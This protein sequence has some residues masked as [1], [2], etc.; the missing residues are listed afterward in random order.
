MTGLIVYNTGIPATNNNPSDDQPHMLINTDSGDQ[1]WDVD[2]VPFNVNYSGTHSQNTYVGFST[3]TF[4]SLVGPAS[5]IAYP[6]A[7]IDKATTAQYYFKNQDATYPLSAV[8]AFGVFQP[9]G[10][11]G[12]SQDITASNSF[13]VVPTSTAF[14][15]QIT[16]A[17]VTTWVVTLNANATTSDNAVVFVMA[18]GALAGGNVNAR[19]LAWSLTANV[20]T[21]RAS[22]LP[23]TPIYFAILQ[24]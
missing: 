16:T 5:S 1:I 10:S 9:L 19:P 7:G 13:N 6:A 2:H 8:R 4:P 3:G 24:I 14:I 17:G 22:I 20:L 11:S 15:T 12:V 18:S 21:I 23:N